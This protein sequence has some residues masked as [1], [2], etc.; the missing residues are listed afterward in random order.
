MMNNNDVSESNISSY[1]SSVIK[2]HFLFEKEKCEDRAQ[3]FG[4][5]LDQIIL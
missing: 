4:D 3:L 2:K 1:D 5:N